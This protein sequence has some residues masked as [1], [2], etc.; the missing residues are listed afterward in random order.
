[1][2]LQ[3]GSTKG[4]YSGWVVTL[5]ALCFEVRLVSSTPSI[6]SFSSRSGASIICLTEAPPATRCHCQQVPGTR[7]LRI[8]C[9]TRPA[10]CAKCL[11][12]VEGEL[13]PSLQCYTVQS[14]DAPSL[15]GFIKHFPLSPLLVCLPLF[16]LFRLKLLLLLKDLPCHNQLQ[17]HDRIK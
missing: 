4:P 5:F 7:N 10:V 8:L 14:P 15:T 9:V 3:S 12:H 1:M 16:P 2:S 6:S 13:R 17:T 11:T